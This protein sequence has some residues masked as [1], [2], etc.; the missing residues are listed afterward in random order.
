MKIIMDNSIEIF[1]IISVL[2][3]IESMTPDD[4]KLYIQQQYIAYLEKRRA[5][6]PSFFKL[7]KKANV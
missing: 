4:M 2:H 1:D 3:R 7:K 5:L 6:Y